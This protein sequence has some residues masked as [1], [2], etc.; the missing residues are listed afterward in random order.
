M[1]DE[2]VE[3]KPKK[4]PVNPKAD[5]VVT[6]GMAARWLAGAGTGRPFNILYKSIKIE[7]DR[8]LADTARNTVI[9]VCENVLASGGSIYAR[10]AF[11]EGYPKK[12]ESIGDGWFEY[13]K[14][15][16]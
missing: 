15:A 5:F 3:K 10:K 4:K 16:E 8:K 13:K 12:Y 14:P 11:V 6:E 1:T 7:I 2:V 9:S